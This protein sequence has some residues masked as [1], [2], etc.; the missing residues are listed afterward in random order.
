MWQA[1]A[2]LPQVNQ[3]LKPHPSHFQGENR[4]VEQVSWY[5]T[6]EFCDRLSSHTK[7]Q[8]RLPSEAEWEYAAALLHE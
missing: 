5:H 2:T 4:P 7:R 3:S 6:V 8:Y 1:V